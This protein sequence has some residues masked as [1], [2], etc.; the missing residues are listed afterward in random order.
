MTAATAPLRVAVGEDAFLVR[1]GIVRMLEEDE[2]VRVVAA[3]GDLDA[4]RAAVERASPDVVLTDIRMPPTRTDEGIALAA[5][6]AETYPEVGV[7]ILS[8]HAQVGYAT[9]LFAHHSARRAYILKERIAD[10]AFLVDAIEAVMQERPMVDPRIV[11]LLIKAQQGAQGDLASL[12]ARELEVLALIAEGRSNG[13][14]ARQLVITRR[15]VE[16]HI[17]TIF[18]K[19]G[20]ED[21][22]A[23]NRRVLATLLF[24]RASAAVADQR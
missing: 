8:Q 10:R 11:D 3:E 16:R 9:T 21:S 20:L 7:V 23:V 22:E 24:V 18:A 13:A 1:E 4:L 19:L 5:E 17:N 15:A 6:L 14:I 12:T 2:R